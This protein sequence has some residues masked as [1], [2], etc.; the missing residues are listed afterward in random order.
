MSGTRVTMIGRRRALGTLAQGAAALG[1]ALTLPSSAARAR[2][3]EVELILAVDVSA[4][5][6][7]YEFDLQ[8]RGYSE[9]FRSPDFIEAL[10][11]LGGDGVA[12]A[13][14][15]WADIIQQGVSVEWMHVHDKRT[16]DAFARAVD[17]TGRMFEQGQTAIGHALEFCLKLFPARGFQGRKRVIDVSGDG[18]SNKGI[19]P[20]TVRDRAARQGITVN[21]LAII[22]E[23]RFLAGYYQRNVIGGPGAFVAV[24]NDFADFGQAIL[25]KLLREMKG[26]HVASGP[27]RM[28]PP[29]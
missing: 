19:L 24:A 13:M 25:A 22:N 23:E 8:M 17:G 7:P 1:A 9:A 20:N 14:V 3:V 5:V 27:V 4:S 11:G 18:Y 6:D 16:A 15:Q 2:T 28:L 10:K 29:V 21:G 26:A 12:V